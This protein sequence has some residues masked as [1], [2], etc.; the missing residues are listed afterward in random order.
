MVFTVFNGIYC[1]WKMITTRT[2]YF[3]L[4]VR[5]S[6][7]GRAEYLRMHD[8][9]RRNESGDRDGVPGIYGPGMVAVR[10]PVL[11]GDDRDQNNDDRR[12]PDRIDLAEC[13]DGH[14]EHYGKH[15]GCGATN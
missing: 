15:Q 8:V 7:D 4:N 5:P 2:T 10:V 11:I 1:L 3:P 12:V 9:I 14:N 13:K 6:N